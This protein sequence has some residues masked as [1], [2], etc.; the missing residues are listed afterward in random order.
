MKK[1]NSIRI[2]PPNWEDEACFNGLLE[3]LKT[4]DCAIRDITLFTSYTHA[5]LTLTELE[6]RLVVLKQRMA[7]A[8]EAGFRAGINILATIGHHC[9]DLDNSLQGAYTFMTGI[10]GDVCK[11]SY[12]M[13]DQKFLE[14]YVVPA[15]TML[16][17]TH[18]DFIWVDD[19]V[20]YGHMPVGLCCFCDTCIDIFNRENGTN[21]TRETLKQEL[22]DGNIEL[23]KAFMKK[24]SDAIYN[25]MCLIAKT[26][27]AIDDKI[28][29]GY[30]TGDRFFEGYEFARYADALS[31]GG[32]YE[33]MWRPGGGAYQDR[34]FDDITDK[35]ACI[36][37]QSAYL[38]SYVT[39]IQSEI[40][41]F[42]Y[43]IILKTPHS[44]AQEVLLDIAAGCSGAALN[45]LPDKVT[46]EM[47]A[48]HLKKI[49]EIAPFENLLSEKIH[50]L[51]AYGVHT[52]WTI[53]SHAAVPEGPYTSFSA[54]EEFGGF[55]HELLELGFPQAYRT[56]CAQVML[57]R[58]KAASVMCDEEI[59]AILRG[60]V[61]MD[62]DALTYLN[63]RGF[64][65]YTGFAVDKAHPVD[66]HERLTADALNLG[67]VGSIRNCR[68][69]FYP[70]D[71]FSFARTDENARI[72]A[73][74][75]D[76]HGNKMADCCMGVFE[77]ALGGRVCVA[78][79]YA[80]QRVSFYYKAMQMKNLMQY[81]AGG[82]W[83][84]YVKTH[85][86]VRLWTYQGKE[87]NYAVLFNVTN[88]A[89]KNAELFV[90]TDKEYVTVY[91]RHMRPKTLAVRDKTVVFES[92][93]SQEV[94]LL[95]I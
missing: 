19:D 3:L 29:L 13:N 16:A 83:L 20:R 66:A 85:N 76:Y 24:N 4:Y 46:A 88:D 42:P 36:G 1:L 72:L 39:S 74:L 81:L 40:E 57:L 45:I 75:V 17:N 43:D 51:S 53:S 21:H 6:K 67:A 90:D 33:I 50:G 95:E 30:M 70:G 38:P 61:Y 44:N 60:G 59:M 15:Y 54:A 94:F 65:K 55:A 14:E 82:R 73:E 78:G 18:P 35:V 87:H 86:R 92:L 62:A 7:K 68:Q 64:G 93:S 9:E 2:T 11:G 26:V 56:D 84:A 34:S 8:R 48:P 12:C 79:Y 47:F 28:Q 89:W 37:R 31:K 77:N 49:A 63:S 91:D 52:G 23:R 58:G 22:D 80:F 25:L 10:H 5:P 41:N 32:K 27:Y 71:S 69:A